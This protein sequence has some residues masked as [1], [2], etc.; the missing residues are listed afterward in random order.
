MNYTAVK[1]H[2]GLCRAISLLL[3]AV[4]LATGFAPA[5]L[6]DAFSVLSGSDADF[7]VLYADKPVTELSLPQDSRLTVSVPFAADTAY[8]WQLCIDS[9]SDIWVD[10]SGQRGYTF[11]LGYAT[12]GSIVDDAGVTYLRC[13]AYA[14]GEYVFT[15]AVKLTVAYTVDIPDGD[16]SSGGTEPGGGSAAQRIYEH[17][18]LERYQP[19]KLQA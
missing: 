19:R 2:G 5:V 13:K 17:P 16:S 14:G 12:V 9:E 8:Q 4:M 10:V 6:G 1:N 3:C 7:T 15:P 18:R 11:T